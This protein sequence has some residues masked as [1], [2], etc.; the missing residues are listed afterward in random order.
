MHRVLLPVD[1]DE[2]RALAQ[3]EY[4]ASLPDAAN[5][6]EVLLLFVF[7]ESGEAVPDE[8]KRFNTAT[9]VGAVRR[10]SERLEAAG[11][12]VDVLEDS[13]DPAERIL[14]AAAER[15]I[16]SIVV[17][18]RKRSAVGKALFG[19]AAQEVLR[20]TT[21]PVVVTGSGED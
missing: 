8:H 12:S 3:A 15:D 5:A 14:A 1:T 9:R 6:V 2:S 10:A 21:V 17:G 7:D 20:G 13:G 16:D 4:V 19:S 18:G 11:V